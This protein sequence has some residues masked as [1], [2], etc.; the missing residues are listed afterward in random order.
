MSYLGRLARGQRQYAVAAAYAAGETTKALMAR[1]GLSRTHIK[2]L[3]Q[4]HRVSRPVGR[5]RK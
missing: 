1:F 3:A 5:P 2:R 4:R